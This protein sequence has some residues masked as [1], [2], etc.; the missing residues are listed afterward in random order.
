MNSE[1]ARLCLRSLAAVQSGYHCQKLMVV[2]DEE[3]L[4]LTLLS[5]TRL[6][7]QRMGKVWWKFFTVVDLC[8]YGAAKQW[9]GHSHII[10]LVQ[11]ID[12]TTRSTPPCSQPVI[13][14]E[15]I[16]NMEDPQ[17]YLHPEDVAYMRAQWAQLCEEDGYLKS[18]TLESFKDVPDDPT[19]FPMLNQITTPV[20]G[21]PQFPP[22]DPS[23]YDYPHPPAVPQAA[24][25]NPAWSQREHD[26]GLHAHGPNF[27]QNYYPLIVD[28]ELWAAG[29]P[30]AY[31]PRLPSPQEQNT[32]LWTGVSIPLAEEHPDYIYPGA[33]VDTMTDAETF[34]P[35]ASGSHATM[36][37]SDGDN[38]EP[39]SSAP[40]GT[41]CAKSLKRKTRHFKS[42]DDNSNSSTSLAPTTRK[43]RR[44]DD[45][46]DEIREG[47]F[48]AYRLADTSAVVMSM[49]IHDPK[50][51][52]IS[53][54]RTHDAYGDLLRTRRFGAMELDDSYSKRSVKIMN[55]LP[56]GMTCVRACDWTDQPCGL[57]VEMTKARVAHHL[58]HWHGVKT[59]DTTPCKFEGC[60]KAKAMLNLG[61]HIEGVHYTTS[62]E[63][64]YCGKHWSRSDSLSRHQLT[65]KPL[66]ASKAR[67]QKG[68][69]NF[70][71]QAPKKLVYGYIVPVGNAT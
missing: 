65:C 3:V 16:T 21:L 43:R 54:R 50:P 38:L 17:K 2:V 7:L 55:E 41:A 35:A 8:T 9:N 58:L 67:A 42:E 12:M 5:H 36:N 19:F 25:E 15:S 30:C 4:M 60:S 59:T 56:E 47:K 53:R 10:S 52:D 28:P 51:V 39:S 29:D 13:N 63:C 71:R 69:R 46:E 70:N 23:Q 22:L 20:A 18:L 32:H 27:A 49:P 45:D 62:Y 33:T 57:F 31:G 61:R 26:D 64:P 44:L 11:S 6:G 37:P 48:G 68:R 34:L 14:P 1:S 24:P 66:L 40:E